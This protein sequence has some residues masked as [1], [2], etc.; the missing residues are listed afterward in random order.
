MNKIDLLILEDA[1]MDAQIIIKTLENSDINFE[2][3]L[4]TNKS[5]FIDALGRKRY[6]AILSDN[7]LHQFNA[8]GA[9][10]ILKERNIH[11]PFILITGSIDDNDAIKLMQDGCS[12]YILKDR[13]Q[14][15]P[16]AMIGS[17]QKFNL[18]KERNKYLSEIIANESIMLEA[19]RLANFGS[20]E[21]N[22]TDKTVRWSD[23]Q[24]RILGYAP[25]EV[26]PTVDNILKSI[27]PDDLNTAKQAMNNAFK[28]AR[29]QRFDSRVIQKD[30]TIR[31]IC[32]EMISTCDDKGNVVRVNG[33]TQ[34]VT[35]T[36]EAELKEKKVTADLVQRNKDLE[37]FAYI[38]SH[39]L[40]SPVANIVGLASELREDNLDEAEKAYFIDALSASVSRLDNV[41]TDLNNI[42]QVSRNV[43]ENKE[44]VQF[45][46]LMEEIR[47]S[48]GTQLQ[49]KH[50]T[51]H[52]DFTELE[53]IQTLKSYM[54]SIFYNL[55]SNSVK[56]R[57]ADADPH[58]DIKSYR[59]KHTTG[60]IFKDN[61]IGIDL[62]RNGKYL[63]GLY[64]RF[65]PELAEGKGMGLYMVKT[66]VETLGGKV[67][68][69]SKINEGTTFR[70]EFL[71]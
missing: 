16:N 4:A 10:Q 65:H 38:V 35:K 2:A 24:Y 43:N 68:V 42:L 27:H 32:G 70:V 31:Y 55:I 21:V 34:D 9:L 41:I 15:L 19:S 60:L 6:D 37:Q 20:W 33:F 63:F 44:T 52:C 22:F 14:R 8:H 64:K 45:R 7:L 29:R 26:R 61:G 56:F 67:Y 12:D 11:I 48:M 30:G 47:S 69:D 3:T 28:Y 54:H 1:Q 58:I 57:R 39:N 53:E 5:E 49:E 59:T 18:E 25:G 51:I 71:V 62:E 50:V 46:A 13:L 36:K 40:R 17:I 23:E 66:Q